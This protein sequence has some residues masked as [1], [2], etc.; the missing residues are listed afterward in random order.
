M[1]EDHQHVA[2][3]RDLERTMIDNVT[4]NNLLPERFDTPRQEFM[5]HRLM[6]E[7]N[8]YVAVLPPAH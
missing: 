1:D 3:L 2:W 8:R 6:R 5:A 7:P 4:I